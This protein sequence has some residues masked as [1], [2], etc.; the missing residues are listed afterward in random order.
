MRRPPKPP[1][2]PRPSADPN[3]ARARPAAP[4][5]ARARR[6]WAGGCDG[7]TANPRNTPLTAPFVFAM[8]KGGRPAGG[9]ALKGGDAAT[10]RPATLW[11]GPWPKGYTMKKQG[12]IILG[13]GGDNSNGGVGTFFEGAM[14]AGYSTDAADDAVAADVAA[15]GYA[16]L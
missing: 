3:L 15:A 11:D 14:L 2:A 5:H 10:G 13:I 9:F 8:A 7:G 12:S 16:M 1:R 4:L 6:L